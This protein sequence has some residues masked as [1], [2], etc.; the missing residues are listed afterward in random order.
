MPQGETVQRVASLDGV[1]DPAC[2]RT[3]YAGCGCLCWRGGCDSVQCGQ[4]ELVTLIDRRRLQ[5]VGFHDICHRYSTAQRQA[6]QCV[7]SL[8]GVKLP[9]GRWAAGRRCARCLRGGGG[10]QIG[11]RSPDDLESRAGRW[12]RRLGRCRDLCKG[13]SRCDWVK[14]LQ[15]SLSGPVSAL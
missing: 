14:I 2:G 15:A 13:V 12:P 4:V 8:Y 10:G 1:E 7:S 3:G 9:R 11:G 6:G 5:A